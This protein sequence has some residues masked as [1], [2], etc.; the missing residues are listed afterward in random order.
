MQKHTGSCHC[1][2]VKFEF[3][4]PSEYKLTE[5]NCSICSMTAYQHVFVPEEDFNILTGED[6]LKTYTFG[7]G[8]AKHMFCEICGIKAFYRPRSHPKSYSVNLR[9]IKP[10]TLTVSEII[11][12]DG[13]NWE[14]NIQG[15]RKET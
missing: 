1:G 10:G 3:E 2:A 8:A 5:C 6:K 14:K 11:K 12:F 4:G 9:C 7:S 13:Q 15:L